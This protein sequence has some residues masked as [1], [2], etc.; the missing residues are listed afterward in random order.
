MTQK[1]GIFTHQGIQIMIRNCLKKTCMFNDDNT[2]DLVSEPVIKGNKCPEY[3]YSNIVFT[4]DGP[5]RR[6]EI[7][8]VIK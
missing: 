5:K 8:K 4:P 7:M 2:C 3:K 6:R 1:E